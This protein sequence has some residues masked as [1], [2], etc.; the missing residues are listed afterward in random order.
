LID[1]KKG[2]WPLEQVK[3]HAEELFSQA[4]AARDA[5][6]LP[7]QADRHRAERLLMRLIEQHLW[8]TP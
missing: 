4:K 5:S 2:K 3:L 6:T 8:V 1:I 7:E